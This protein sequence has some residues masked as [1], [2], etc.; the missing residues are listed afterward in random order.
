MTAS[1]NALV[2]ALDELL[3]PASFKDYGPNGLQ[4]EGRDT[5]GTLVSGVT[6]SRALI[7]AAIEA[8]ADA[9]LVH[10]GLFWRGHDGRLT[11]WMKQRVARLLAHDISLI[12]YRAQDYD[13]LVAQVT[14]ER[15]AVHFAHRIEPTPHCTRRR[16]KSVSFQIAAEVVHRDREGG[17]P[18]RH[19]PS[20]EVLDICVVRAHCQTLS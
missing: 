14:P 19:A 13:L 7:D 11:G 1:R 9:I 16:H 20:L 5:V 17:H 3:Q 15:V 12:A 2:A 6:A 8:G 4:V 10:H 18:L